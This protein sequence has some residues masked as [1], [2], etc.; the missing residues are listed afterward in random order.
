M[1]TV[2]QTYTD[3]IAAGGAYEW[4]IV[5]GA[6]TWTIEN[7]ASGS[8]SYSLMDGLSI[9]NCIA[10]QLQLTVWN[11]TVDSTSPLVVKFRATDGNSTVSSWYTK[12]TFY[13]D[14]VDSSPYSEYS[15]ITAFDAMLKAEV[16]ISSWSATTD[17]AL[18]ST[19]A[20]AMGVTVNSTTS[21]ALSTSPKTLT[22]SPNLGTDGTT[23]REML[24]Y[25]AAMRGGNW[26][27][28]SDNELELIYPY[29][30]PASSVTVGD[31]VD[32]FD[33][34]P[35]ETVQRVR[36]WLNSDTYFLAPEQVDEP[37]WEALGGY[38]LE[39]NLPFYGSQT[40]AESINTLYNGKTFY[41]YTGYRAFIPPQYEIG[42]GAVFKS[43]NSVTSL[44]VTQTIDVGW[45]APSSVE[46]KGE[47]II[48]SNY[49]KRSAEQRAINRNTQE[50][51]SIQVETG[52]ITSQVSQVENGLTVLQTQVTQ[53][54]DGITAVNSRIDGQESYIRWDGSTSTVSI[55]ASSAPTEA[56]ISPDGFAV[57]Q[58]GDAILEA[59]GHHVV[60][61]HFE[62]TSTMTVGRYQWAD[63]G[64][65]GYTLFYIG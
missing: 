22:E 11:A 16:P 15:E 39:V 42:D 43:T 36:L 32:D 45:L 26:T 34:S 29:A 65:N 44:L 7:L 57:V 46:F 5:N 50:I 55:G 30:T 20:T 59:K 31:E 3:I 9:G 17:S 6:N 37:T 28:N 19:I 54:A 49:P 8:I 58:N 33:T 48:E 62:A 47:E 61:E 53:N 41:P 27:I 1:I 40:I 14:T 52:Q 10:S 18:V 64:T 13:I 25:I 12:G 63:E 56:Q 4:Q 35:A 24:S 23:E 38:C 2:N 60:T 51:A 21:T